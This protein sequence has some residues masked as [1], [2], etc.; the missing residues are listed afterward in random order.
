[1]GSFGNP[2]K[3]GAASGSPLDHD[4]FFRQLLDERSS[5]LFVK[6]EAVLSLDCLFQTSQKKD[7]GEVHD[8]QGTTVKGK[9]CVLVCLKCDQA[10][11]RQLLNIRTSFLSSASSWDHLRIS[12]GM[13]RLFCEHFHI[14]PHFIDVLSGFGL[15]FS[16]L[17]EQSPACYRQFNHAGTDIIATK[18]CYNVYHVQKHGRPRLKDPWSVRQI[19]VYQKLHLCTRTSTWIFA[20]L[21]TSIRDTIEIFYGAGNMDNPASPGRQSHPLALHVL[22]LVNSQQ[23]W[24]GYIHYLAGR[25][26]ELHEVACFSMVGKDETKDYVLDFADCQTL[27]LTQSKI[28]R[29]IS[30][31]QAHKQVFSIFKDYHHNV[32]AS[33]VSKSSEP[34]LTSASLEL[35]LQFEQA[36]EMIHYNLRDLEGLFHDPNAGRSSSTGSPILVERSYWR[37]AVIWS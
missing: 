2:S 26:Q 14:F 27:E 6:G 37:K 29:M 5:A 10:I 36:R 4:E 19:A 8:E 12:L 31:L 7:E 9:R 3:G 15:K 34:A 25:V 28:R 1:M 18:I 20:Q 23:N 35:N 22:I 30:I 16:E 32:T 33:M 13:F 21:P 11:E 24:K 17:D